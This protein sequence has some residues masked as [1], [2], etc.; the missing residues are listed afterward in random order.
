[1]MAEVFKST[2][3]GLAHILHHSWGHY[4][5][6]SQYNVQVL[7]QTLEISLRLRASLNLYT[8]Q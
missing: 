4:S 3:A 8:I 1:M 2:D 7:D 5:I 6:S